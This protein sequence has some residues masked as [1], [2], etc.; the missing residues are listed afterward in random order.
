V[1]DR[2]RVVVE[3]LLADLVRRRH[4]RGE[5]RERVSVAMER[6][7]LASAARGDEVAH[8][9]LVAAVVAFSALVSFL[10]FAAFLIFSATS[11]AGLVFSAP[12]LVVAL[13]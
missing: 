9:D 6:A 13:P 7:E 12:A 3:D 4:A 11:F 8:H 10:G 1:A 5:Q 2:L